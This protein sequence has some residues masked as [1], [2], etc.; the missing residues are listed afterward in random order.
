MHQTQQRTAQNTA[1]MT[2]TTLNNYEQFNLTLN[3]NIICSKKRLYSLHFAVRVITLS[4]LLVTV[5]GGSFGPKSSLFLTA[6]LPL[7]V[8][9]FDLFAVVGGLDLEGEGSSVEK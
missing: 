2:A 8:S 9:L 6:I 5:A 4:L 1:T 7:L 3:I